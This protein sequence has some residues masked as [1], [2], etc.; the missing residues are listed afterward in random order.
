MCRYGFV[1][2][3]VIAL[4]GLSRGKTALVDNVTLLILL[5]LATDI[6]TRR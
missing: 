4:C 1:I 2:P 5:S 6:V 3:T